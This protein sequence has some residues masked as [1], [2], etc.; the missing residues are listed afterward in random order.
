MPKLHGELV[1]RGKLGVQ[2][3]YHHPRLGAVETITLWGDA[4]GADIVYV[5]HKHGWRPVAN[6]AAFR[7]RMAREARK[8]RRQ[9]ASLQLL[10]FEGGGDDKSSAG[11]HQELARRHPHSSGGRGAAEGRRAWRS[12]PALCC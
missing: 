12:P 8:L 2:R 9:A 4:C 1:Y 5:S 10:S 7:R 6:T 3:R 11:P